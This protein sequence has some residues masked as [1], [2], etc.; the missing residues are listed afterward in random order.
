MADFRTLGEIVKAARQNLSQNVWDYISG[1]AESETTLG[2]N[3]Q[4][5]DAIAFRPRVLKNV[6]EIDTSATFLGVKSRIPVFTAPVGGLQRIHP[7]SGLGVIKAD[8]SFGVMGFLSS[9]TEPNL[10]DARAAVASPLVFQLYIRGDSEWTDDILGRAVDLGYA[11]LCLTVDTAYY[12]RRER[13]IMSRY[14]PRSSRSGSAWNFQAAFDWDEVKR[15]G[16]KFDRPLMLKGIATAED[17]ARAV[18][19]GVEVIYVSNHG[20]RQLDHGRGTI[21]IL[22]EVVDAVGGKADV[23]I[24]GGFVRGSDVVKAIALGARAVGIGKLQGWGL[25]ADGQA[26]VLRVLEILEEEMI[27]TMGNLGVSC[28][29]ELGPSHL[30]PAQPE[31]RADATSAGLIFC[32]PAEH[33]ELMSGLAIPFSMWQCAGHGDAAGPGFVR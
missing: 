9:V 24:D 12:G 26:G 10:A 30:G 33:R 3:R 17:A 27:N 20:G 19:C 8:E 22:P 23:I 16:H 4:A 6:A 14:D 18:E 21:E 32:P 1:G 28:L 5:L 2:R 31:A 15:I 13:D 11:G 29:D 7:E 25:A